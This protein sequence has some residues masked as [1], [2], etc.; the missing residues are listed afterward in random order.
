MKVS[1]TG[2]W[3]LFCVTVVRMVDTE[4]NWTGWGEGAYI[5]HSFPGLGNVENK[6]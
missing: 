6:V 5:L 1:H 2:M 3:H 4:E